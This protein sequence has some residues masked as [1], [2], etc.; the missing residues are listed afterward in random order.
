[1]SDEETCT[2]IVRY[3]TKEL[4]GKIT[5]KREIVIGR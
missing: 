5:A 4:Y 1:V 3:D 2:V